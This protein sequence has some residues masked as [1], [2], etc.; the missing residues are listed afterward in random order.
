MEISSI[1]GP[2]G[3]FNITNMVPPY[4]MQ[5]AIGIYIIEIIFILTATL[6]VVDSGEDKL[7]KTHD[8]GRNLI[9]GSILYLITALI[10]ILALSLLAGV[11][12]GGL[13]GEGC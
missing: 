1:V 2:D 6:V 8:I 4:F 12:L 9:R 7:R 11:A 5:V 3:L 13:A 10:S